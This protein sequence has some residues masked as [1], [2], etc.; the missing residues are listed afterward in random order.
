MLIGRRILRISEAI[1][2]ITN[3]VGSHWLNFLTSIKNYPEHL[4]FSIVGI[5]AGSVLSVVL[6]LHHPAGQRMITFAIKGEDITL[7][8]T[9]YIL[10]T[11]ARVMQ[12]GCKLQDE[13]S[14]T[15]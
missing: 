13:N 1:N 6:T 8:V 11:M 9:G 12:E 3:S 14:L 7:F 4:F 15:V 2:Q 10:S 5:V